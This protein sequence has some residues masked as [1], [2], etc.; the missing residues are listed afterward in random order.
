MALRRVLV[1][2]DFLFR[3]ERD[4][5]GAAPGAPYLVSEHELAARL[6]F[7][8]WSSIPDDELLDLADRGALRAPGVLEAQ[9]ER[10]LADPRAA[11]LVD[12]FGGQWL[13]LRN[14]ALVAP[15]P[16][17][18]ADFD[19]NLREAMARE[20]ELFP[21]PADPPRPRRPRAADVGR[22]LRQPAAGRALR[23]PRRL[24]ETTSGPSPSPASCR[25]GGA[26]SARAA[27]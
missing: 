15:D 16:Y 24:R 4:P 27:C 18:F 26:C 1:S 9:V 25:R 22:D 7:F 12:N 20:M 21:R 11:S 13:Y 6:S 10:M 17:A 19:A 5:E 8:L 14:M 3:R 2:P 23:H